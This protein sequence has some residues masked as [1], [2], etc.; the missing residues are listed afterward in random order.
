MIVIFVSVRNHIDDEMFLFQKL[1]FFE[2]FDFFKDYFHIEMYIV[3]YWTKILNQDK[4][5]NVLGWFRYH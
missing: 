5:G 2:D 3:V 4:V 1:T